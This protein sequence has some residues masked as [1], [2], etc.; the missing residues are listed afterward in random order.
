METIRTD[1]YDPKTLGA[2]CDECP[3]KGSKVVP[4]ELRDGALITAIAEAPGRTE[5]EV[6]RP[7]VG[8]SG[9]LFNKAV[10]EAG[11]TREDCSL[12]N[13]ILCMPKGG[14]LKGYMAQLKRENK[15]RSKDKKWPSPVDCCRPRL[16][17]EMGDA[18]SVLLMGGASK[19]A[20]LG[21]REGG[22]KG[23]M[24]GRGFPGEATI[25][26]KRRKVMS[27]VHP[28]F[29]MRAHRWHEF[30]YSD[31]AK[32]FRMATDQLKW[33]PPEMIYA[34][35][36][37]ELS[38]ALL[39][40]KVSKLPIAYDT[41]TDGLESTEVNLRC[42]GI[43]TERLTVLVPFRSVP[44]D[45]DWSWV[46]R[47]KAWRAWYTDEEFAEVNLVLRLWFGDT[48]GT[49]IDQNGLY[50]LEI[51][52]RHH[53]PVKRKRLDSAICH[54]LAYSELP[55][56][57]SFLSAQYTDGPHH[58]DVDHER[59]PSDKDLWYYCLLDVANTSA[60]ARNLIKDPKLLGQK[61][62][63]HTDMF[64]S[65]FCW[66]MHRVGMRLITE[67][68]D[69]HSGILYE[70]MQKAITTSREAALR[71]VQSSGQSRAEA[72][73]KSLNPDSG[74]Q[75]R[76]LLFDEL[77]VAPVPADAGGLT[78]SG[79]NSV[80]KDS[81]FYLLDRGLPPEAEDLIHAVMDYREPRKL[82]DYCRIKAR[83]DGRIRPSWNP[84]VVVTGRLSCSSP[85]LMNIK[86][87]LRSIF[88]CE[89]SHDLVFWDF[90]QLEL[91]VIAWLAQ[92]TELIEAFLTGADI[93]K[94]NAMSILGLKTIEE[95]TK[96]YRKF[97][98]TF[99]YAVQYG[100]SKKRAY[101]MIKHFRDPDTG[102]RPYRD[103]TREASDE[104]YDRWWVKRKAIMSW[105]E[106]GQRV[107]NDTGFLAEP[108]DGRRRYFL[109]GLGDENTREAMYNF[110][111]QSCL[112]KST[113][114]L[115]K[116]GILPIGDVSTGQVW[117]GMSWEHFTR[118]EMGNCALGELELKNGQVLKCDIRHQILTKGAK[119]YEFK[120]WNDIKEGDDVCLSL[121]GEREF[122]EALDHK[123]AYWLG[124]AVGNGSTS[125]KQHD[126]HTGHVNNLTMSIGDRK[127]RYRG[128]KKVHEFRAYVEEYGVSPQKL[129]RHPNGFR[130]QNVENKG[131]RRY[132]EEEMGYC[133]GKGAHAKRVPTRIWSAD[134]ES[135]RQ[136]L[137]GLFDA[138]GCVYSDKS[139]SGS[140]TLH[141][142]NRE[143]LQ[144]TMLLL[145]TVGVTSRVS[146]PFQKGISWRL[147]ANKSQMWRLLK[148]GCARRSE[149]SMDLTP[150]WAVNEL[151]K[152]TGGMR[153]TLERGTSDCVMAS[154][155]RCGG[156]VSVQTFK[157][158]CVMFGC[159]D[160]QIYATSKL[161][162]KTALDVIEPTYTLSV[163]HPSHRYDSEGVISKNCSAAIV[164][165]AITKLLAKYD[166]GFA[167]KNT[168][169]VHYN[170]DS[171]GI[172]IPEEITE[173]IAKDGV[174]IL[175][176]RLGDM[177]LPVD[178]QIGKS[179]G[180]LRDYDTE[181]GVYVD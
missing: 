7:L 72:V 122:G 28:A 172:E 84:H 131:F 71:A 4:P 40:M 103:Y 64:L 91:R 89:D 48:S 26:G 30:F 130:T 3:L 6:R 67:E 78:D 35:K 121:E 106:D 38:D 9:R 61:K 80:D 135:R 174:S 101:S 32:A 58:K 177:P 125:S 95:V 21:K 70:R 150:P 18:E 149:K 31:V 109:D 90:A 167:G 100:A 165:A 156:T 136:F 132:W 37:R 116:Q 138:D 42:I 10:L 175:T 46:K 34:P 1:D 180:V 128:E 82:R 45:V 141:M 15:K 73:A 50:D 170:Y 104:A 81:L 79:E 124:Y 76:R 59:W 49:V 77:G 157:R 87:S 51:M 96:S 54:H 97:A 86:G 169:I 168:G 166:W 118:L 27:T 53:I 5:I 65:H 8:K 88:G 68:Q 120:H 143:L 2:R 160:I 140:P 92:D 14:N 155:M 152:R 85:N 43:G 107:W 154:R 151:L 66:G 113:R 39:R 11:Y 148:Y 60:A 144:E 23:L 142:C 83:P 33:S 29:V 52:D 94:V 171:V 158:F 161:V 24:S 102:E 117:T 16:E 114:I 126:L 110:R 44:G 129:Y 63:L 145:R 62:A 112:P 147:T 133:W 127:A 55:H 146:G 176:S 36:A 108:V 20:L 93:H 47:G 162:S 181:K 173:D 134:L 163:D 115:T 57:L 56:N 159:A 111:V 69:R 75:L 179:W 19:K 99:T 119:S 22:E 12:N 153:R 17:A 13:A 25:A 41:E 123:T 137:L 139:A 164:N 105:Y 98:K 74:D 178:C